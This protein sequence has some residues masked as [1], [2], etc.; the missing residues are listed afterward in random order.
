MFYLFMYFYLCYIGL[1]K[2]EFLQSHEKMEIY[3]KAFAIIQAYFGNDDED[4]VQLAP[5]AENNQFQFSASDQQV[6]MDGGF[7]F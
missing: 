4:D 7:Q 5:Q 1:D 3:E 6:P 2:I